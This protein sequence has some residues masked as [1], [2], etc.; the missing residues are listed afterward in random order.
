MLRINDLTKDAVN[1]LADD[2][3][4]R[5]RRVEGV[6]ANEVSGYTMT[7]DEKTGKLTLTSGDKIITFTKD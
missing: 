1:V 3:E 6:P 7:F 5:I 2:I 4:R